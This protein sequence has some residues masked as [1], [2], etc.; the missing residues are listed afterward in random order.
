MLYNLLL[1][2]SRK[3]SPQGGIGKLGFQEIHDPDS[4]KDY[5]LDF[6]RYIVPEVIINYAGNSK[7]SHWIC[8]PMNVL[9][10]RFHRQFTC[11]PS[12]V[13]TSSTLR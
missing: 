3:L 4:V 10:P 2:P 11:F 5:T 13:M 8:C 1:Y 6:P 12:P 9:N 7:A